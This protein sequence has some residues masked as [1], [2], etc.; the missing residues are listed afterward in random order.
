ME[1]SRRIIILIY[2]RALSFL[3][4]LVIPIA[5]TRFL[6]KEDYRSYQQL[7]MIY[8]IIQAVLLLGIPQSLLY[9]YPR[10][11]TENHSMLVKQTWSIVAFS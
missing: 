8:S 6:L 3:L 7:I 4:S 11:E 2:G 1:L 9:F 10:S 5:L